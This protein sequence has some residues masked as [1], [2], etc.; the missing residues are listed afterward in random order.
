MIGTEDESLGTVVP[1][2]HRAQHGLQFDAWA[3]HPYPTSLTAKPLEKVRYP[4]V[5]LAQL[6]TFEAQLKATFHRTVPIW[7]TEY[8]HETKP[9]E[10][11]GVTYAQQAT[12]AKQAV[13]NAWAPIAAKY[14]LPAYQRSQI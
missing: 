12:Y 7:V 1:I 8:G 3:H 14:G 13:A 10:P 6:P 2:G 5:T 4:N 11:H 9:G